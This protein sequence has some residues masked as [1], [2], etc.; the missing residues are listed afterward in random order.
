MWLDFLMDPP[1]KDL[2]Q[3]PLAIKLPNKIKCGQVGKI[4]TLR[5]LSLPIQANWLT[6]SLGR[7]APGPGES[8]RT[9][10]EGCVCVC[11]CCA[12]VTGHF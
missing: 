3:W 5:A 6:P 7:A 10:G 9:E 4:T 2:L 8:A 11:V 12:Q 1:K